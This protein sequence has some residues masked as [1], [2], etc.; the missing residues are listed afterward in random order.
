M[1]YKLYKVFGNTYLT[2]LLE[3]LQTCLSESQDDFRRG[4]SFFQSKAGL[5]TLQALISYDTKD[6]KNMN[7]SI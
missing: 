6:S 5:Y 4:A 7:D 3:T 1:Y 2:D